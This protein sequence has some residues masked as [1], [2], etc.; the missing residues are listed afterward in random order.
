M[1][2]GSWAWDP[3]SIGGTGIISNRPLSRVVAGK[4]VVVGVLV[5]VVVRGG[6]KGRL[7]PAW[8]VCVGVA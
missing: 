6:W 8:G 5:P 3:S 7:G 1:K 4:E 2:D